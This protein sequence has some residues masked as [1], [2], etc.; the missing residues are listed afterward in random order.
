MQKVS[1]M[2]LLTVLFSG[3]L[4]SSFA[5][6]QEGPIAEDDFY[7]VDEATLFDFFEQIQ[8]IFDKFT[9]LEDEITQLKEENALLEKR[10]SILES[11]HSDVIVSPSRSA[12]NVVL[13]PFPTY[14]P[15][16]I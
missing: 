11:F 15:P 13:A 14:E 5:F 2:F 6:A 4:F 1:G 7:T 8:L 10:I 12:K 3:S 9:L 16:S